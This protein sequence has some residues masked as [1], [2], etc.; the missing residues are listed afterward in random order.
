MNNNYI[1]WIQ[2]YD[3]KG[4]HHDHGALF[5]IN[6]TDIV[7]VNN[8]INQDQFSRLTGLVKQ[9]IKFDDWYPIYVDKYE[10]EAQEVSGK[11]DIA[12]GDEWTAYKVSSV[13]DLFVLGLVEEVNFTQLKKI[14]S[15]RF[16]K[17]LQLCKSERY[18]NRQ[19]KEYWKGFFH[20]SG[21]L[22]CV[23][24]EDNDDDLY[25]DW[26]YTAFRKKD[27]TYGLDCASEHGKPYEIL[28]GQDIYGR[29]NEG[30]EYSE[31]ERVDW[32]QAEANIRFLVQDGKFFISKNEIL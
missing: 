5:D 7:T 19:F 3:W 29:T 6:G 16:Q 20:G 15:K 13:A 28:V 30:Y 12:N 22:I 2:S 9:D 25:R 10:D 17:A 31:S 32:D 11:H 18:R 8:D 21:Y 14:L 4:K 23:F 27:I 24:G 26:S 1:L